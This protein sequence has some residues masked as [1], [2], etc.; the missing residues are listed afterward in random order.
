MLF[1]FL[2][3]FFALVLYW[4]RLSQDDAPMSVPAD[5]SDDRYKRTSDSRFQSLNVRPVR[6]DQTTERVVWEVPMGKVLSVFQMLI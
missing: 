5:I 2:Y 6:P 3:S 1:W 4:Y